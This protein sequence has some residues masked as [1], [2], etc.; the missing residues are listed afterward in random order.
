MHKQI[1][2]IGFIFFLLMYSIGFAQTYIPGVSYFGAH[3]YIEYI[4]GTLPI[5]ISAPHGGYLEPDIIPDRTCNDPVYAN[6]AF[7]QELIREVQ[8][9]IYNE[10]GCYAHVVI[11]LLDR[12]KLDAN[13]NLTEGACGNDSAV[14]AW[15]D[16]NGFLDDAEALVMGQYGKGFYID[17]HGHGNPI[18][19]LEI[20][21]LLY[22][23]ELQLSDDILNTDT[24]ITYSSILNLVNTN[25]GALSHA[26][27]LR[28][29]NSFGTLI[30]DKG[31]PSVP[32]AADPFPNTGENYYSGGYNTIQRSS[33]NGGT[34]DGIQIECNMSGV[35]NTAE[36]RK[37]FADSLAAVLRTYL[38]T[39]Y[40]L[41][42]ELEGCGDFT[43]ATTAYSVNKIVVS[44]NPVK[45]IVQFNAASNAVFN[46]TIANIYGVV[47][48]SNEGIISSNSINIETLAAGLY[49]ILIEQSNVTTT[50]QIIKL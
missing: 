9:S 50:H 34:I 37:Q 18:Q 35:R 3:N 28:G 14:Q 27:L 47:L 36:N 10:F 41:D 1:S 23:D 25:A 8:A 7:T 12:R 44:P 40:F 20:G 24:Y 39:H 42:Y 33:Y 4:P 21:Y 49:F 15:N 30:S 19:R 48:L 29:E 17:L 22:D 2:I 5:I 26:A 13:R 43:Y 45:D 32:S 31:Y 11:N 16:F 46:V 38:T 6:D